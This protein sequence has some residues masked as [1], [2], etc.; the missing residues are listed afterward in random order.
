M[1]EYQLKF[2][3]VKLKKVNEFG[4]VT[5]DQVRNNSWVVNAGLPIEVQEG[6]KDFEFKLG[7]DGGLVGDENFV[8]DVT[9][10]DT[11]WV[12]QFDSFVGSE[13]MKCVFAESFTGV[14]V[15]EAIFVGKGRRVLPISQ[16]FLVFHAGTPAALYSCSNLQAAWSAATRLVKGVALSEEVKELSLSSIKRRGPR[17]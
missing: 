9:E 5:V 12:G 7:S 11:E 1:S 6:E 3:N 15:F 10:L 13:L 2:V 16:R 17:P 8:A 14:L 4:M